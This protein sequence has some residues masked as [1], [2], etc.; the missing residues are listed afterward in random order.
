MLDD[1]KFLGKLTIKSLCSG[2]VCFVR[3]V[4]PI[5]KDEIAFFDMKHEFCI[6]LTFK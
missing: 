4:H 6:L 1:V 2:R 5:F 3:D